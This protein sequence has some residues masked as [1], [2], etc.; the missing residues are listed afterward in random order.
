MYHFTRSGR[1]THRDSWAI[2]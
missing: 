2:L 1:N